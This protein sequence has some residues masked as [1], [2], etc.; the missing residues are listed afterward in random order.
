MCGADNISYPG[1]V[2]EVFAYKN[3]VVVENFWSPT[4]KIWTDTWEG[5]YLG[6]V[7]VIENPVMKDPRVK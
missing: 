7:K 2:K 5:E 4:E 6:A 1:V 3:A